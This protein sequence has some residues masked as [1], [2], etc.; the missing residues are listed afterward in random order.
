MD[1]FG[2]V[3]SY[4]YFLLDN[5]LWMLSVGLLTAKTTPKFV[6]QAYLPKNGLVVSLFGGIRG[7]KSWRNLTSKPNS[8][9]DSVP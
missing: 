1:T 2:H 9:A 6:R 5:V 3:F 4:F 7:I 8:A